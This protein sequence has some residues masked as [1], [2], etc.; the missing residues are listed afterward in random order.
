MIRSQMHSYPCLLDLVQECV[1]VSLPY[2]CTV[3][4]EV[5]YFDAVLGKK[6]Y[7]GL[8]TYTCFGFK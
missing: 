3:F 6:N 5:A 4:T 8:F 1:L 2:T 7:F